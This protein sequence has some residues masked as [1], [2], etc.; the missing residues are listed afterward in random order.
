VEFV[1][2]DTVR[3]DFRLVPL[4]WRNDECLTVEGLRPIK[5]NGSAT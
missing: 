5:M 1:P 4:P 2:G 3:L